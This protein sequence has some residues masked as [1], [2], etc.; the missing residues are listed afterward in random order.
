[1][2]KVTASAKTVDEAIQKAL[3][4]LATTKDNVE[5]NI[6]KEPQKA[7]FGL[8]GGKPAIVEVIVKRDAIDEAYQ[9]LI[10]LVEKMGVE[11]EI[12]KRVDNNPIVFELRGNRLG[13]LIGK[14]G[15][16]LD[17][18]QFLVNLVANR[19]SQAYIRIQLD[20]E[21]YRERRKQSLHQLAK[22]LAQKALATKRPVKLEPMN[23]SE[24][25]IIH[26]ALHDFAEVNTYSEGEDPRRRIVIAPKRVNS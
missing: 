22:R 19:Y 24:R 18:L 7:F 13:S 8:F 11:I 6:I 15:Q 26:S 17:S 3:E 4:Q 20:A 9:F 14:R 12:I 25:K 1:V 2:K 21:N 10:D 23:G 5:I 16:T